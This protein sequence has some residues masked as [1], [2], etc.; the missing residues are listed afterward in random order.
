[1]AAARRRQLGL[2]EAGSY[3][4]EMSLLDELPSLGHRRGGRGD[5]GPRADSGGFRRRDQ[6]PPRGEPPA[7]LDVEQAG[8]GSSRTPACGS[9]SPPRRPIILSLAKLAECRDPETG[10]HLDRISHYCRLLA[11]AA[12][13]SPAFRRGDRR[14]LRRQHRHVEPPAR[15]REGRHPGR[16]SPRPAPAHRGGDPRDAAPSGDRRHRDPPGD[17]QEPGRF[18]PRHGVR[19]RPLPPRVGERRRVPRRAS[20]ETP[21]P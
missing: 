14:G 12:A 10:A 7:A 20:P 6:R 17:G 11:R 8:A 18:L 16:R 13:G 19:H 5:A 2:L 9:S 1:M 21:S 4:G 15:H 3:F